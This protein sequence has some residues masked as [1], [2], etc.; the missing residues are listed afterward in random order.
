VVVGFSCVFLLTIAAL[1][2]RFGIPRADLPTLSNLKWFALGLAVMFAFLGLL[3]LA[4]MGSASSIRDAHR[5]D[6]QAKLGSLPVGA[7][8]M[9]ETKVSGSMAVRS[10]DWVA[11][12]RAGSST[13]TTPPL[14]VDLADG[15]LELVGESYADVDWELDDLEMDVFL[16]REEP[17]TV[18][19]RVV[20]D[21][22]PSLKA[23]TVFAGHRA[24]DLQKRARFD[25]LLGAV[26]TLTSLAS[27]PGVPLLLLLGARRRR[28]ALSA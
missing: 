10:H 25:F 9:L 1:L 26:G 3:G 12:K 24:D 16:K 17:V 23:E 7:P 5:V 15:P 4:D 20:H 14:V 13:G 22:R 6:E 8:V 28:R 11:F 18:F 27:S 21:P 19:G 2:L